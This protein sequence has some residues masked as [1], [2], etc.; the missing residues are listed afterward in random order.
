L[1]R[2]DEFGIAAVVDPN[3]FKLSE[4]KKRYGLSDGQ[5][6]QSFDD[7]LSAKLACDFVINATMDQY[8]YETAMQILTAGYD[9]L[10]EKPIVANKEQLL[11]IQACAQE[12]GCKVFVCHVLRYTPY[13]KNIKKL[14]NEEWHTSGMF[15]TDDN[16]VSKFKGFKG[17]Y[18]IE[19]E[20]VR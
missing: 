8:H 19:F 16:G 15:G 9:M 14:I 17:M 3:E 20:Y 4:A 13:Y 10:M 5:L 2:P 6:F 7:F 11:E 1:D 12:K 18:D